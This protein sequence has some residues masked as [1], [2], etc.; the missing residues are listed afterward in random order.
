MNKARYRTRYSH[1]IHDRYCILRMYVFRI[2]VCPYVRIL[3]PP[4]NNIDVVVIIFRR[5]LCNI[6][7]RTLFAN[8]ISVEVC[9]LS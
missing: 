5:L 2:F 8:I 7:M 6:I 4:N 1:I 3:S 9:C